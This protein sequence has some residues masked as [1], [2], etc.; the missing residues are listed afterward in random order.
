MISRWFR[1]KDKVIKLRKDGTSIG[2]INKKY[3][4]PKSTLSIWFRKIRLNKYQKDKIYKLA[5]IKMADARKKAVLWHNKQKNDR[6]N[7]AKSEALAT[8]SKLDLN[9]K[10]IIELALSFLYL[11]EGTK[12]KVT[13]LGNTNPL[14]LRFFITS[15]KLIYENVKISKCELHLRL[16]QNAEK[17]IKYWSNE[18]KI[19]IDNFRFVKDKRKIKSPTYQNY[20]GVCVIRFNNVGIQRR[21]MFLS[22]RFCNIISNADD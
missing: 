20:H 2:V 22:N 3:G 17:E 9:D 10:N 4:I 8:L 7:K 21:L 15:I 5:S 18:L 19:P 6:I 13:S 12:T 14:I 11:G 1:L 16:D